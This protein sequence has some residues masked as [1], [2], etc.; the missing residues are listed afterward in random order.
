[1]SDE[2]EQQEQTESDQAREY[3]EFLA[4][5]QSRAAA[6]ERFAVH[7]EVNQGIRAARSEQELT[8]YLHDQDHAGNLSGREHA[9][10]N[11]GSGEPPS[12]QEIKACRNAD[13]LD[14]LLR[15][16]LGDR[17]AFEVGSARLHQAG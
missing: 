14:A 16:R 8:D 17:D 5:K 2:Q 10:R 12:P 15:S 7:D 4:F 13:E 11:L 9:E 6:A 1:M 3:A